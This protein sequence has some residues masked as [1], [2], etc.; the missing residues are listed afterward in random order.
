MRKVAVVAC[1]TMVVLAA[2][3]LWAEPLL[4]TFLPGSNTISGWVIFKAADRGAYNL[5]G[6]YDLYDGDVPHL[7]KFGL[8]AAHQRV[9]KKGTKRVIV[10]LMRLDNYQHAKALY[11]ERTQG[12]NELPGCKVLSDVR[13]QGMLVPTGGVTVVYFWQRNYLCSISVFGTGNA[14]K[15]TASTFAH[16]ISN[17]IYTYYNPKKRH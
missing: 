12:L 4:K 2:G 10:D 3:L 8:Q 5:Q 9:Y 11:Q 1:V 15:Q 13:Q 17:R 7:Q 16:W 6:L 14:E